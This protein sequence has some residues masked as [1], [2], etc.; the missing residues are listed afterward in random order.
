MPNCCAS[1][2]PQALF[3]QLMAE[4]N[5]DSGEPDEGYTFGPGEMVDEFY[6]GTA[7]LEEYEISDLVESQFGYHIIMRL[8]SKIPTVEETKES[9]ALELFSSMFQQRVTDAKVEYVQ[10]I[11][12]MEP[13]RIL[14]R[15]Q[16]RRISLCLMAKKIRLFC[17]LCYS[18]C[19]KRKR[20]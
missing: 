17:V 6:D 7:A 9:Y 10:D 5:E 12:L 1:N 8:P 3:D 18:F 15:I 14:Y 13:Q 11:T 19:E 20:K 16:Q 2:D 4:Y